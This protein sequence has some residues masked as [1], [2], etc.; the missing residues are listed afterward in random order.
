M[1]RKRSFAVGLLAIGLMGAGESNALA[2]GASGFADATAT[3]NGSI[4][5]ATA[6]CPGK[7]RAIGGGF[8]ETPPVPGQASGI[9]F[10]SRKVGQ[11]SWVVSTQL[12]D[13]GAPDTI[14]LR[15]TVYCENKGK[16]KTKQR[17]QTVT[18]FGQPATGFEA[19]PSC[20][21]GKTVRSGGFLTS[22]PVVGANHAHQVYA[23]L[24]SNV[25]WIA[26]A[27]DTGAAPGTLTTLVDC[28]KK[29]DVDDTVKAREAAAAPVS[30][31]GTV[32]TASVKCPGKRTGLTGGFDQAEPGQITPL[33][34]ANFLVHS[35]AFNGVKTWVV[36]GT[37]VGGPATALKA[38]LVCAFPPKRRH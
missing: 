28:A 17:S 14:A 11:K 29:K 37:H 38:N 12:S 3:G 35:M 10:E 2:S 16:L 30:G 5:T 18:I 36:T 31:N 24:G 4:A 32:S 1:R 9:V 27:L 34:N 23:S 33:P 26:T 22:P 21:K 20:G 13:P 6:R 8:T 19:G 15:T 7:G 25:Q